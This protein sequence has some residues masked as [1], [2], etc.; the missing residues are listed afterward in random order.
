MEV[1]EVYPKDWHVRIELSVTQV[2]Q[3]LDFL[4]NCEFQGDPKDDELWKAN[5][6]VTKEFFPTL[7][8]LAEEMKKGAIDGT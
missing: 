4:D 3:L 2:N 8:R 5:N 6:Y 1:L 7:D